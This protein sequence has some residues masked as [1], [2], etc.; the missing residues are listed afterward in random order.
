MVEEGGAGGVKTRHLLLVASLTH[1]R[2][3]SLELLEGRSRPESC[4]HPIATLHPMPHEASAQAAAPGRDAGAS[5]RVQ[6]RAARADA[7]LGK[8]PAGELGVQ[9][10]GFNKGKVRRWLHQSI[11]FSVERFLIMGSLVWR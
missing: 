1:P 2:F 7:R 9:V 10:L 6:P 8:L 5:P 4:S 3:K 11:N